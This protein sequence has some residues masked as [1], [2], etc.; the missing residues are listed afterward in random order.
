MIAARKTAAVGSETS[1]IVSNTIGRIILWLARGQPA[2]RDGYQN[3]FQINLS[4]H[5]DQSAA[6]RFQ[7]AA[8]WRLTIGPA[9]HHA[10]W[11]RNDSWPRPA[12]SCAILHCG[13][14]APARD[15]S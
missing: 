11:L 8:R 13:K 5:A 2:G 4:G 3:S 6:R 10:E 12:R 15:E 7:I 9:P 1:Q 14:A